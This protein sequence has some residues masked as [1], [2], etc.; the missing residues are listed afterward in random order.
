[1]GGDI[2]YSPKTRFVDVTV[3]GEVEKPVKRKGARPGDV[4]CVTGNLGGAAGGL[5]C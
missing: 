1:M 3:W 2:S 4:I 5:R